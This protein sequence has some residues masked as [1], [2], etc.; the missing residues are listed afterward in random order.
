MTLL[1][2]IARILGWVVAIFCL[3]LLLLLGTS[4]YWLPW[5][6]PGLLR[7][8][9]VDV[10]HA[11]RGE[12]GELVLLKVR[13]KDPALDLALAEFRSPMPLLLFWNGVR[14][15]PADAGE[16]RL[17][18][19]EVR[20]YET[21]ESEPKEEGSTP[22]PGEV[23][24]DVGSWLELAD[25]WLPP[26]SLEKLTLI[27]PGGE[28]PFVLPAASFRSRELALVSETRGELPAF[29]L[30]ATFPAEGSWN[31]RAEVEAWKLV[32]RG[33]S[34]REASGPR[35]KGDFEIGSGAGSYFLEWNGDSWTPSKAALEV[36]ELQIPEGV[37]G[38]PAE[39]AT[40]GMD[41]LQLEWDGESYAVDARIRGGQTV[42]ELAL[43]LS[44]GGDF[45]EV[46]LHT[47]EVTGSW[48]RLTLSEPVRLNLETL[49]PEAPFRFSAFADLGGQEYYPAQ[50]E[51]S[52]TL[53]A[54]VGPGGSYPL[55][56][57]LEG[58]HL[59]ADG[60]AL[61]SVELEGRFDYP[62]LEVDT[63][64]MELPEGS[65]A[66]VAGSANVEERTLSL[67]AE[68]DLEAA[69]IDSL[70]G[71]P[72]G[73]DESLH[74]EV[75]GSGPWE[76]PKHKGSARIEKFT[77]PGV[78]PLAL[79]LD[80]EGEG[81]DRLSAELRA[82][83]G[84]ESVQVRSEWGREGLALTGQL[85]HAEW[86]KGDQT[87]L[88]LKE[89]VEVRLN[90]E[91]PARLPWKGLSVG[92][93]LLIGSERELGA[94]WDPP[95]TASFRAAGLRTADFAGWLPPETTLPDVS[96]EAVSLRVEDFEP[97]LIAEA[98]LRAS[99]WPEA[100]TPPISVRIQG[101]LEETGVDL[102][103][104]YAAYDETSL[105]SGNLGLPIT[106][107]P[108][109]VAT[110]EGESLPADA[111]EER[112]WRIVSGGDLSGSIEGEWGTEL[113]EQIHAWGGPYLDDADLNLQLGGTVQR[114][115]VRLSANVHSI[116][117]E[118]DWVG[119]NFPMIKNLELELLMDPEKILLKQAVLDL[120]DSGIR[121]TG[122][123][124]YPKIL[125]EYM[126]G[127]AMNLQ[128]VLGSLRADAELRNWDAAVWK[129]RLPVL[130]RPQGK[131][132][133]AVGVDPGLV[134]RGAVTVSGF[135]MRSTLYSPPVEN[136]HATVRLDNRQVRLDDAGASIGG[137][138]LEASG[139][140]DLENWTDP[141][142][143]FKISASN[144]PAVRTA[145]M[146]LRTDADLT[147]GLAPGDETPLLQG[148]LRLRNSTYLIS[149]DPFAPN[150]QSGPGTRPPYFSVDEEPFADWRCDLTIEGQ[151][152]LRVR[153]SIFSTELSANLR[154][155]R[156]LGN[157]L[158]LGSVRASSGR[159]RFPGM[160]MRIESA[161]AFIT[162][163]RPNLLQIE[164]DAVGQNRLYV[165]TMNVSG[166]TDNP[167]IQFSSTP[168]LSNAQI[169]RL[170]ATGSLEGGGAGAIGLYLGQALLGPGTG[171]ETLADRL[172][173]EIGQEV[174]ENG[175]STVEVTY[176][177][178]DRWSI[179]G[180]YDRY[181]TYNLNLVRIL[182]E[183]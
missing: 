82:D 33:S 120:R 87:F 11:S 149:F 4:G 156:T 26:V 5:A 97:I 28:T 68:A 39:L 65:V 163:D 165:V 107:H 45:K 164:A 76:R 134:M 35:L 127:K 180:E 64:R 113:R 56:F 44:L 178:N 117:L 141:R 47:F 109:T 54:D 91:E 38:L 50:G 27:P 75:E 41:S 118:E 183:R 110:E 80:W 168:S 66:K 78:V 88:A 121:L 95:E 30:T 150:I 170:L 137:G 115:E 176:R 167:Q 6:A 128:T 98:A 158:L 139:T 34:E 55:R 89:P 49:E 102:T 144:V 130:L 63:F 151:D 157:P 182:L 18:G 79:E 123:L 43:D 31:L 136:I 135:S 24:G 62:K 19:L 72:I 20:W 181:D 15:T 162:P 90:L 126:D 138:T 69:D 37:G 111:K 21:A 60:R 42:E 154:L 3:G 108:W 46:V 10:D 14:R 174:T 100:E 106:L 17:E 53:E 93:I 125:Q 146:I 142:Y 140:V 131:I 84:E 172:T 52:G 58:N 77:S 112:L 51:L 122:E 1:K 32:L 143:T 145:D 92:E 71:E 133:G 160:G 171:E 83:T 73:L 177:L 179:E 70:T 161:E 116:K 12:N 8:V 86:K 2:R 59:Q 99:W 124:P 85:L 152:F 166:S 129:D 61:R 7:L 81:A 94:Q 159:V 148:Q 105:L 29:Q 169:I 119:E 25:R 74:I 36:A 23:F 153:S 175:R 173:V 132:T 16:I 22:G 48:V 67:R 96:L 13:Y 155:T 57:V 147:F 101:R 103:E 40:V 9:D 104:I 114:P